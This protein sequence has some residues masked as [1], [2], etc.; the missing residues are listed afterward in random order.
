MVR[1]PLLGSSKLSRWSSW[2][3]S[4]LS[5]GELSEPFVLTEEQRENDCTS[6]YENKSFSFCS[7]LSWLKGWFKSN[8]V[9]KAKGFFY[10]LFHSY[11]I[12]SQCHFYVD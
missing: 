2:H 6:K 9:G 7:A 5:E 4:M 11:L 3:E 1:T 12:K 10:F 8:L